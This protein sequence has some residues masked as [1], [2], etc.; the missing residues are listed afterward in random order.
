MPSPSRDL[1]QF[2]MLE[3]QFTKDFNCCGNALDNLHDLLQHIEESHVHTDS[4]F[5]DEED[6]DLPIHF[7]EEDMDMDDA[8]PFEGGENF[9]MMGVTVIEDED[10]DMANLRSQLAASLQA[11]AENTITTESVPMPDSL[12]AI[13]HP[14][15]ISIQDIFSTPSSTLSPRRSN[16]THSTSS[17]NAISNPTAPYDLS[18]VNRRKPG[19]NSSLS[20]PGISRANSVGTIGLKSS[21]LAAFDASS[22]GV[23]SPSAVTPQRLRDHAAAGAIHKAKRECIEPPAPTLPFSF[24]GPTEIV[25]DNDT[26]MDEMAAEAEEEEEEDTEKMSDSLKRRKAPSPSPSILDRRHQQRF[27]SPLSSGAST[28]RRLSLTNGSDM[29]RSASP[30]TP[31]PTNVTGIISFSNSSSVNATPAPT[32][33]LSTANNTARPAADTTNTIT[34]TSSNNT[35]SSDTNNS[36][37]PPASISAASAAPMDPTFLAPFVSSLQTAFGLTP[38]A[39]KAA[40]AA[41]MSAAGGPAAI[42]APVAAGVAAPNAAVAAAAVAA[43]GVGDAFVATAAPGAVPPQGAVALPPGFGGA[44][45]GMMFLVPSGM[46]HAAFQQFQPPTQRTASASSTSSAHGIAAPQPRHL[47]NRGVNASPVT[48]S[49]SPPP[50]APGGIATPRT[51]SMH[52]GSP[53]PTPTPGTTTAGMSSFLMYGSHS[54][55]NSDGEDE[56]DGGDRKRRGE[57]FDRPYR[58][59]VDGCGKA[60]KN[61][62]GLK[63]HVLHGHAEDTGDPEINNIIQKPY[64]CTVP[65]CGKRYKNLNGLKYHIEHAHA[66][67]VGAELPQ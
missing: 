2:A 48:S 1:Q 33:I 37:T 16:S 20:S 50:L 55:A 42:P 35:T 11:V 56:D 9:G 17:M 66:A 31:T 59:K 7:M 46:V 28:P 8:F 34:S 19:S 47:A 21:A 32:L 26:D 54:S 41:A 43:A 27:M 49:P 65:E 62:G 18:I 60:Y 53:S 52:S 5:E 45:G 4:D 29:R 15:G 67:L 14:S 25:S 57:P 38:A 44:D 61:P 40:A 58:C 30:A 23:A 3:D 36:C 51:G 10:E 22:G 39:A 12:A 6:G 63:Y 24:D 13:L 64:L